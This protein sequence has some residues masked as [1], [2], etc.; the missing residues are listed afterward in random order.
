MVRKLGRKLQA[1]ANKSV[2]PYEQLQLSFSKGWII[3][4]QAKQRAHYHRT[5]GESAGTDLSAIAKR[6]PA[7]RQAI[8]HYNENDVHNAD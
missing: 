2:S 4:F 8:A 7:V 1:E 6:L 3:R 5:H